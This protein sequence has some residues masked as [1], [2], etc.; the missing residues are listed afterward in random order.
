MTERTITERP[1]AIRNRADAVDLW[2]HLL[3]RGISFHWED[4][5]ASWVDE[6][7][8]KIL[9]TDEARSVRRL[10]AEVELLGDPACYD[11]AVSLLKLAMLTDPENVNLVPAQHARAFERCGDS[12]QALRI[13][14]R[15]T[16]T[17]S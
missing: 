16:R 9:T 5:P 12:R 8:R 14:N 3:G 13:L 7:R 2:K 4:D 6:N 1:L 17:A 11:A 10:F 15:I